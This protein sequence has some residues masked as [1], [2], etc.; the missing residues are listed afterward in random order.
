MISHESKMTTL[1][2]LMFAVVQVQAIAGRPTRAEGFGAAE[3]ATVELH[4]DPMPATV[5]SAA[6]RTVLIVQAGGVGPYSAEWMYA[7]AADTVMAGMSSRSD[8]Y[9]YQVR[10]SFVLRKQITPELQVDLD[11][12]T[13][14][15]VLIYIGCSAVKEA[16]M[17]HLGP[18]C[19][20]KGVFTVVYSTEPCKLAPVLTRSVSVSVNNL[21]PCTQ[22]AVIV[23]GT[24]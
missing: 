22:V 6:N 3:G 11:G 8:R 16:F 13:A 17:W 14:G 7:P 15:D 1:V 19:H 20:K 18:A 24:R 2:A 9:G 5:G 23:A 12:L 4:D 21:E 10:K